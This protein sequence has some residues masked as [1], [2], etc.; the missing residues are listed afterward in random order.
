MDSSDDS[1][2][3]LSTKARHWYVKAAVIL[4]DTLALLLFVNVLLYAI[5]YV[6]DE[7]KPAP[8]AL[9]QLYGAKIYK[10]YS[11][12]RPEDVYSLLKETWTKLRPEYEPFTGFRE[13]AFRGKF[14][15]IHPAGFRVSRHQ[16]SWPPRSDTTSLFVFGGSTTFG[17]GLPDD[18]TIASYLGECVPASSSSGRLAVYNFARASY[19]SSQELILFQQLL[20]GGFLPQL[21]VFIDGV[22]DSYF[23]DGE[24]EYTDRLR[25][26]MAGTLPPRP[27]AKVAMVRAAHW[28]RERWTKPKPEPTANYADPLALQAIADRWVANK[29]MIQT[30]ADRFGVKT[31]FVWQPSP[32][33]KY[34][35][36]YHLFYDSDRVFGSHI[37]SRYGYALMESMWAQ[38]KLGPNVLWLAGIQEDKR[39]NLYVDAMHYNAAF[40]SEIAGRICDFLHENPSVPRERIRDAARQH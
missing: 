37:R 8:P 14:V 5:F 7:T 29:K 26:F 20:A 31:V 6:R 10:A 28:L 16:A 17:Y 12:W 36:R 4:F 18:E 13:P 39:E 3:R 25:P 15:N 33:Y 35:L 11:G 40:S 2:S 19:F 34:D 21:A 22:N 38:G 23:P 30:I 9:I 1:G 32:T 27:F 24:P